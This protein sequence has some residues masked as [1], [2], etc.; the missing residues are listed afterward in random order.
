MKEVHHLHLWIFES[1]FPP[2]ATYLLSSVSFSW[3]KFHH[4]FFLL[5]LVIFLFPPFPVKF[6]IFPFFLAPSPS[7]FLPL[8]TVHLQK[9]A[10]AT[11]GETFE[12]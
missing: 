12:I 9:K 6:L 4:F 1:L 3:K 11:K 7:S 5:L 2:A 10:G 8:R